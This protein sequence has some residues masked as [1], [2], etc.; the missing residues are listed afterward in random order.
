MSSGPLGI[1]LSV[2]ADWSPGGSFT[3][4]RQNLV[5]PES[6]TEEAIYQRATELF[7]QFVESYRWRL[8]GHPVAIK[9]EEVKEKE[10]VVKPEPVIWDFPRK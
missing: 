7:D 2:E 1:K 9:I 6:E 4:K 5:S 3:S 10:E 8:A